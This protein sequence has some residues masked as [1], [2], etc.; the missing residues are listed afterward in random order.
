ME[1]HNEHMY[2]FVGN[3]S[4]DTEPGVQ[5]NKSTPHVDVGEPNM[6][7]AIPTEEIHNACFNIIEPNTFEM[8]ED[9]T[10]GKEWL[11]I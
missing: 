3:I 10:W 7:I 4:K 6:D 11:T 9:L 8:I 1:D 5:V 2:S